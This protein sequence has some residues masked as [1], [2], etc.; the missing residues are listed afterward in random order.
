MKALAFFLLLAACGGGDPPSDPPQG[1]VIACALDAAATFSEACRAERSAAAGATVLTVSGPDGR[2]RRFELAANGGEID[3]AD[4]AAR[5][6]IAVAP[7]GEI[8]LAVGA[9]RYRLP[10][11][12]R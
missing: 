8:E 10:A 12:G 2:F 4:G 11:Q 7:G 6:R 3:T 5:A 1:A 9:D